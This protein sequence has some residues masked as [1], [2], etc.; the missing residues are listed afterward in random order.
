MNRILIVSAD[1]VVADQVASVLPAELFDVA[2]VDDGPTG[3]SEAGAG[4]G[5]DLILLDRALTGAQDNLIG[6][7]FATSRSHDI[8]LLI[9]DREGVPGEGARLLRSGAC[10]YLELPVDTD[11]LGAKIEVFLR[12]RERLCQLRSQAVID[13]LTGVYNRRYL[14]EQ[15]GTRLG[16][17]QRYQTPFSF[18]LLDLDHFKR[19]NDT[20]GHQFGD[21]VLREIAELVRRQIRKEDILARYGGEEFAVVLPHTDRLGGA[22]LAERIREAV[23]D[24]SFTS[25]THSTRVTLSMGLACYP[26]DEVDTVETLI[27]KADQRMYRAKELGRNQTIFE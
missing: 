13:E 27:G 7:F 23:A 16:E 9:M 5:P 12:L 11:V 2:Q 15:M 3:L 18:A 22:I 17:A 6:H 26:I 1:T 8:P 20:L 25:G 19:V 10:A 14:D 4:D 24:H 21:L